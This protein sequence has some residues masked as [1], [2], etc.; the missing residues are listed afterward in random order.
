MGELITTAE[1]KTGFLGK[2][3]AVQIIYRM[4]HGDAPY[5]LTYVKPEIILRDSVLHG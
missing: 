3:L 2:R 5:E 1:V 4:E